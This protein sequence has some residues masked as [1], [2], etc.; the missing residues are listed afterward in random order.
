MENLILSGGFSPLQVLYLKL[1]LISEKFDGGK[2]KVTIH[3]KI[4][5]DVGPVI[6]SGGDFAKNATYTGSVSG[7]NITAVA[8]YG[9]I[10][11]AQMVGIIVSRHKDV[12]YNLFLT[13]I[14][15]LYQ[16]VSVS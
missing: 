6:V 11:R 16:M 12:A 4:S 15:P 8:G 10:D 14:H 3:F 7:A 9:I 1:V 5:E 2:D 13:S